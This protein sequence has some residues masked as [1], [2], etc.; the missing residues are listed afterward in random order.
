MCLSPE[1]DVVAAS[2]MTLFAV[3]ALRHNHNL[4]SLPIALVPAVFAIHTFSD[5]LVWWGSSGQV[6]DWLAKG[7]GWIYLFIAFVLL[8]VFEQGSGLSFKAIQ[9]KKDA[10]QIEVQ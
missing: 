8:P 9:R 7:A 2:A 4:R 6:S 1:V 5:A 3:D 10:T